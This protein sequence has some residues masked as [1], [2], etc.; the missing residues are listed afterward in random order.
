MTRVVYRACEPVPSLVLESRDA[1][2]IDPKPPK[3]IQ[4]HLK[5]ATQKAENGETVGKHDDMRLSVRKIQGRE[6]LPDTLLKFD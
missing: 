2:G 5:N 3:R 1:C 6:G 4:V